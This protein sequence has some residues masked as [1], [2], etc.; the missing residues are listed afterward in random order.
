MMYSFIIPAYNCEKYLPDCVESITAVGL[1]PFEHEILIINDGS[2]DRTALICDELANRYPQVR[3]IHQANAG[4]SSARNTGIEES[5][6]A[7]LLF[8]D[9]DDTV[10]ANKMNS[11][12]QYSH[13]E[14][15]DMTIFG[16]RFDYFRHGKCYRQDELFY[17]YDG[18]MTSPEWASVFYN[19]FHENALSTMCNKV[20]RKDIITKHNL[21]LN[22]DMFLYEDLDFVLRYMAHCRTIRN[23]PEAVY[24]YRQTE[25][26]GN[27]SRRIQRLPG[28]TMFIESIENSME[29]LTD[30]VPE[31]DRNAVLQQLFLII[32]QGKISISKISDI[33][34]VCREFNAWRHTHDLPL[35]AT[36]L[37][38]RLQKEQALLLYISNKKTALRHKTA[39]RVKALFRKVS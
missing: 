37:Q 35:A 11:I 36:K 39:V 18:V 15:T 10:D 6:G 13:C 29:G 23:V 24:Q 33:R 7:F 28:I 4:V 19:L 1:H 12:L 5:R 22:R 30:I 20:F 34:E 25:D 2:T 31:H 26:E 14:E 27:A 16:M 32:A 17:E 21:R 3:V 38:N 9:S 8:V